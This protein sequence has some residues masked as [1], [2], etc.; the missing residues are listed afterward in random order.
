MVGERGNFLSLPSAYLIGATEKFSEAVSHVTI[1]YT[2]I[3]LCC[4]LS[5]SYYVITFLLLIIPHY[6]YVLLDA[7]KYD[8]SIDYAIHRYPLHHTLL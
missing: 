5:L 7:P 8:F 1:L 6:I 2:G 4:L 3:F